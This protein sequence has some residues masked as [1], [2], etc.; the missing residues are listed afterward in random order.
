LFHLPGIDSQERPRLGHTPPAGAGSSPEAKL[1]P[2][3]LVQTRSETRYAQT[4]TVGKDDAAIN[5]YGLGT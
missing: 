2:L 1:V 3:L 5:V 4:G